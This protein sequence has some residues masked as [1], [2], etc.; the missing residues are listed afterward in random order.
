MNGHTN[1]RLARLTLMSLA[2]KAKG[3]IAEAELE[4]I[5]GSSDIQSEIDYW[6]GYLH[7]LEETDVLMYLDA[8]TKQEK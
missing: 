8:F 6:Q 5:A 3:R 4:Q 7:A 2:K 1:N